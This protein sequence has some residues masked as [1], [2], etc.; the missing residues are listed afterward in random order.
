M[1]RVLALILALLAVVST[2]GVLSGCS[3][4]TTEEDLGAEIRAFFVEE[5]YDFDPAKAYTNDDAMK[6]MSLIYEPLFALDQNGNLQ[7]ALADGYEFYENN[8]GEFCLDVTLRETYWND[9]D[10]V[11]AD[12]VVYAWQRIL[13]PNFPSQAATLLYDVKYA[14]EAKLNENGITKYDAAISAQ[15]QT[16]TIVFREE[17]TKDAQKNFLRNLTSVALTPVKDSAFFGDRDSYWSKRVAT[18]A[19]NGPFAIRYMD[20]GLGEVRLDKLEFRLERNN[21]YRRSQ[22]SNIAKDT[23]VTPYKF[24]TYWDTE[25]TDAFR[26]YIEG[27]IF[28]VGDIPL[29]QRAEYLSKAKLT[30]LLSTY[31]YVLDNEDPTFANAKVRRALS[32]ALNR[33]LIASEATMGLSVP[34]TGFVSHGVYNGA[35]GSFSEATA[36]AAYAL[37]TDAQLEAAAALIKEAILEDGY[38][39]GSI[40]VLVRDNAEERAIA[41]MVKTAWEE[42]FRQGGEKVTVNLHFLSSTTFRIVEDETYVTMPLD[43]IQEAYSLLKWDYDAKTDGDAKQDGFEVGGKSFNV[44]AMDY[45]MLS[46]DAFGALASFSYELSGNGI[47]LSGGFSGTAEIRTHAS[48]FNSEAFNA[49]IQAA[50]EEKD[51]AKR[52]TLLH[53][54][55]EI[56]LAEMPVIPI[57]FNRSASLADGALNRVYYNYYGYAVFTRTEL[58]NYHKHLIT[59]D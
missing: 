53:E 6:V 10:Q 51:M 17:L 27:A 8:L 33:A 54:A 42:V 23:H 49:K 4:N 15:D 43:A 13:D 14:K 30:N 22:T 40:N 24:L 3:G 16:V 2:M 34:A 48:G 50:Y 47:H 58:R 46:P 45:Q 18:I 41:E 37:K 32:M 56:L 21:Y 36:K 5:V 19:T 11:T 20:Y 38:R 55:E 12:D 59:E 26:E 1:K 7:Y 35:S 57:L 29:E 9:G 52:N 31:T 25:L 44:I 28:Y 39:A